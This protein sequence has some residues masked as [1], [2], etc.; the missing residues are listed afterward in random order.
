MQ[1]VVNPSFVVAKSGGEQSNTQFLIRFESCQGSA[2]RMLCFSD[3][4]NLALN[5]CLVGVERGNQCIACGIF[6]GIERQ[7]AAAFGSQE[8]SVRGSDIPRFRHRDELVRFLVRG[9][10]SKG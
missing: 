7:T 5:R 10:F 2:M 3:R 9:S 4:E 1:P 8:Q 6:R